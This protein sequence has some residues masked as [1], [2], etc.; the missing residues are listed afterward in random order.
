M[1]S[2]IYL[3]IM[4]RY[5]NNIKY[6]YTRYNYP[7]LTNITITKEFAYY[8]GLLWG[9]G[10][11]MKNKAIIEMDELDFNSIKPTIE[12]IGEFRYSIRQ[13]KNRVKKVTSCSIHSVKS[14][15]WLINN[16]DYREKSN[17]SPNKI[18]EFIPEEFHS[19]FYKGYFDADGCIYLG[20]VKKKSYQLYFCG[21]YDQD[22]S[23]ITNLF[24]KLNI[25]KYTVKQKE[26][27]Q[28]NKINKC[29]IVRITNKNDIIKLR[30]YFPKI[31]LKRKNVKL[32]SI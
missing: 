31:G 18:L 12:T 29:S 14:C 9:D 11:V 23:F 7:D 10:Y 2:T 13:R 16:F 17:K 27:N 24:N 26:Q 8:L 6:S 28:N 1:K 21:S 5:K 19:Y 15:L 4:I 22:W 3:C 20:S 25:N 30:N 32:S